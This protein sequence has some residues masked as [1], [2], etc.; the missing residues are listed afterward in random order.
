MP[1]PRIS[2]YIAT[3]LD[4]FIARRDGRVD[5]LGAPPAGTHEDYGYGDFMATVDLIVMG[6][7]SFAM[8]LAF[9]TWPYPGMRVLVLSTHPVPIPPQ[10]RDTVSSDSG[11]PAELIGRPP[12]AGAKHVYM[13]GGITVQRFLASGLVDE[14]TVTSVPVLLGEGRPLFGG[15][16]GDIA[17]EHLSTRSWS[18]GYVQSAYRVRRDG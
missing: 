7:A 4:G 16:G 6:R 12:M 5:W 1:R 18:N 13:D 9:D 8:A 11:A 3:S 10:L 15:T 2:V 17:L 14:I